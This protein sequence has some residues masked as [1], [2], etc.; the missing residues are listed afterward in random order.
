MR[1]TT[2]AALLF[3]ALP[4]SALPMSALADDSSRSTRL[5]EMDSRPRRAA[6]RR[7]NLCS[8]RQSGRRQSVCYPGET[9]VGLQGAAAYASDGRERHGVFGRIPRGHGRQVR[10]E[11]RRDAAGRR[12]LPRREGHAALCLDLGADRDPDSRQRPFRHQLRQSLGR[13]AQQQDFGEEVGGVARTASKTPGSSWPDLRRARSPQLSWPDLSR[14]STSCLPACEGV[15]ARDKRGHDS[16]QVRPRDK[17]GDDDGEAAALTKSCSAAANIRGDGFAAALY[18]HPHVLDRDRPARSR[19]RPPARNHPRGLARA[20]ERSQSQSGRTRPARVF[21]VLA[22]RDPDRLGTDRLARPLS[23]RAS[24]KLTSG[25]L[26]AELLVFRLGALR[27]RTRRDARDVVGE[28]LPLG[29][30]LEH[31]APA[32]I[33]P[34]STSAAVN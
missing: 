15:D 21:H 22:G 30:H 5:A 18:V 28:F 16:G 25:G 20:S 3:A 1:T 23:A 19:H 26:R 32:D 8:Q 27:R 29:D 33:G 13:S 14:P 24:A 6:G 4:I 10:H 34:I 12:L 17:P 11:K 7:A 31:H 9:A 2:I